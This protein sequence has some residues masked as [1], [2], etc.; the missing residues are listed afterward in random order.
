M[1]IG[2]HETI[3]SADKP[4]STPHSSQAFTKKNAVA[5]GAPRQIGSSLPLE[6]DA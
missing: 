4:R 5:L 6:P 2:N 3:Q 1:R